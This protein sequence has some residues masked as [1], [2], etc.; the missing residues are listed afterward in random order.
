MDPATMRERLAFAPVARLATVG[1]VATPH[2]VPCCHVL[3]GD[4]VYT[5]VDDV[6]PK[7]SLALRRLE[8]LRAEPRAA[9][10]VDHYDDDW[11]TLWWVRV[12]GSARLLDG[13]EEREHSLDALVEK[14]P[15]Y[16]RARPPGTVIALDITRW[17]AWP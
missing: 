12:D 15:Q 9:L 8:N 11:S 13:G 7:A 14:Y 1:R 3:I 10:L 6:K 5:A 2:L 16:A 17:T 4:V